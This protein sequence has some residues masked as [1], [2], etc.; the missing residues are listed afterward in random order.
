MVPKRRAARAPPLRI[1][2][3]NLARNS[4]E[5]DYEPDDADLSAG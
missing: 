1:L 5:A 4:R 2:A 3:A